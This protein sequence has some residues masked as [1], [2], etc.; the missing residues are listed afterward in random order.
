[1]FLQLLQWKPCQPLQWSTSTM[2]LPWA[3]LLQHSQCTL[4]R[5]L[6]SWTSLSPV[7]SHAALAQVVEHVSPASAESC[8]ALAPTVCRTNTSGGVHLAHVSNELRRASSCSVCRIQLQF[9]STSLRRQRWATHR[10]RLQGMPYHLQWWSI[11]VW[12]QRWA[13]QHRASAVGY[14]A[15][16]Q[17]GAPVQYGGVDTNRDGIPD[18]L[19]Q[20]QVGFAPK[21]T[22]GC[23]RPRKVRSLP[24]SAGARWR[25]VEPSTSPTPLMRVLLRSDCARSPWPAGSRQWKGHRTGPHRK[26]ILSRWWLKRTSLRWLSESVREAAEAQFGAQS[27]RSSMCRLAFFMRQSTKT[28]WSISL[29]FS[30]RVCRFWSFSNFEE[31]YRGGDYFERTGRWHRVKR[32]TIRRCAFASNFRKS[33]RCEMGHA[34]YS[35]STSRSF[36]CQW[37]EFWKGLSAWV[38]E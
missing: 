1:M 4:H 22:A 3:M 24:S 18:V 20:S 37:L 35:V 33:L 34:S 8:A 16:Q 30:V 29:V 25:H 6:S 5:R 11:V 9:W 38:D 19:Q 36:M 28:L 10:Q 23:W 17:Y 14:A 32:R 13:Q 27:I 15:P 12:C 26:R 2:C 31:V 7:V 21:G